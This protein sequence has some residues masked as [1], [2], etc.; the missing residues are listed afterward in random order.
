M[1]KLIFKKLLISIIGLITYP[2]YVVFNKLDIKGM[3]HLKNLPQKNVLFVSN[4]QTYFMEVI[5][6]Y[7]I[8]SAAK[9][10]KK[11]KLGIPYYLLKPFTDLNYVAAGTTM[12]STF[13]ARLF[14]LTGAITVKRTWTN[15]P[16]E[17]RKGLDIGDTR[18]IVSAI[19]NN[20][21]ITFPQGTTTPFAPGRKGTAHIIK[22]TKALVIPIV[23]NGFSDAFEKKG[24]KPKKWNTSLSINI[25]SPL[26]IN[27]DDNVEAIM[28]QIMDAIEQSDA[29]KTTG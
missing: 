12:K 8:M 17:A 11:N 18:N 24:V 28:S 22:Q 13:L 7:H 15:T 20:W 19:E 5:A 16:G 1:I 23:I 9:W 27:Y 21:V 10:G 2:L 4:H 25:K 29:Y 3:E 6:F 26:N 14:T